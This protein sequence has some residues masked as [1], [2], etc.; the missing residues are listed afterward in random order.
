MPLEQ[1]Q[2]APVIVY[3]IGATVFI[4][5]CLGEVKALKKE[6]ATLRADVID[7]L[8]ERVDK[9]EKSHENIGDL[10]VAVAKVETTLEAMNKNVERLIQI[11]DKS[12]ERVL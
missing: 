5:N 6:N 9:L 4:L 10:K 11:H 3:L 8:K 1:L 2:I 12:A 7:P